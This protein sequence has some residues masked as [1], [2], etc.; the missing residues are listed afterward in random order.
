MSDRHPADWNPSAPEVLADQR[1][2]CDAMRELCP[3][4]HSDA[5]DWSLFRHADVCT[6]LADPD[7]YSNSS[8]HHA[9]PNALN[10]REHALARKALAPLFSAE[11]MAATEPACREIAR[12]AV[13]TL[14]ES[15]G[16]GTTPA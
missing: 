4:A 8:R 2:A 3:V 9:I 12:C 15:G 5:M 11:R 13:V 7:T 10:G 1:H 14:R 6:V 16:D